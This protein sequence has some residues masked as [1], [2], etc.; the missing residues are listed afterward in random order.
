MTQSQYDKQNAKGY[1]GDSFVHEEIKKLVERFKVDLIVETGTYRGATTKKLAEL[2]K[3]ISFE[4]NENNYNRALIETKNTKGIAIVNQNSVDG[5]RHINTIL[6]EDP[7]ETKPG[8]YFLDAHWEDYWP[9]LDEL[10]L[11]GESGLKPVIVIHDFKVPGKDFGFDSYKGINL[12]FDY[13]KNHIEAIYGP[14]G[15]EYHYNEKADGAK[16]GLIYIYPKQ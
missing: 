1:E 5:L 8:L 6:A 7:N 9:L 16:R 12:D 10:K 2:A 3:V 14:D 4:V 13:I 15:Y 11:I